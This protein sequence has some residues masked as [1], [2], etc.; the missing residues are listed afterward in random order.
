MWF[1]ARGE[2]REEAE[3]GLRFNQSGLAL[4]A[5][6]GG[7]GVGAGEAPA[8]VRDIAEGTLVTPL[9][10]GDAPFGVCVLAGMAARAPFRAGAGRVPDVAA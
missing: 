4:E 10:E 7:Q 3:R 1:A 2:R 6:V 8:G 5:A 9:R